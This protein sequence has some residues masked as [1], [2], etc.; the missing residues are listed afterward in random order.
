MIGW[1][2]LDWASSTIKHIDSLT[3]KGAVAIKVWKNMS[4]DY[5]NIQN[6]L[7]MI[8]DSGFGAVF[9]LWRNNILPCPK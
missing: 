4:M 2:D 5:R 7:V 6:K 3:K 1:G 9:L 8:D